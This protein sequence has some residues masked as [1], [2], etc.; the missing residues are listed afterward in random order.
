MP[1]KLTIEEVKDKIKQFNQN[2]EIIDNCYTNSKTPLK[3]KCLIDGNVF[4][5]CWNNLMYGHGC[6]MCYERERTLDLRYVESFVNQKGLELLKTTRDNDK[7]KTNKLK[8]FLKCKNGH[9]TSKSWSAFTKFPYCSECNKGINAKTTSERHRLDIR[10]I[11]DFVNLRSCKIIHGI[12]DYINSHNTIFTFQ[13]EKGHQW[14]ENFTDFKRHNG[15]PECNQILKK[16]NYEDIKFYL[17]RY[18]SR[19]ISKEVQDVKSKF[20]FECKCGNVDTI[21]FSEFRKHKCCKSCRKLYEIYTL[22]FLDILFNNQNMILLSKRDLYK[23]TDKIHYICSCGKTNSKTL[24]S[25]FEAPVCPDCSVE[26]RSGENHPEWHGGITSLYKKFRGNVK[27]W[28]RETLK[29]H[30][31]QCILTGQQSKLVH[32]IYGFD[33]IMSEVLEKN[34]LPIHSKIGK[35]TDAELFIMGRTC[36]ALHYKYGLGAVLHPKIHDLF[37]HLYKYGSNTP[38]QFDEF[39]QRLKSGEF[40]T[41]LEQHDLSLVI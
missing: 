34:N 13:C 39:K 36:T 29:K 17:F 21:V 20:T 38:D 4:K 5:M 37:H 35:Y 2:I 6:N 12:D 11:L 23:K 41:Y 7:S 24:T 30:N 10:F 33:L 18:G 26:N 22:D 3:C 14:A 27:K 25:W 28:V 40:N 16:T 1:Q 8:L 15:C 32:H 31:N 19:I 9:L